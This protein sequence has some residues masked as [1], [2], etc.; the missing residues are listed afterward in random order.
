MKALMDSVAAACIFPASQMTIF[1]LWQKG[2][3][4]PL[5]LLQKGTNLIQECS[6][7]A[8]QSTPKGPSPIK[9]ALDI[10]FQ[11]QKIL[12]LVLWLLFRVLG[13]I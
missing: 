6:T 11:I 4:I 10:R 13:D 12:L 7:H 3:E 8:L 2:G 1:S 9:V 5:G